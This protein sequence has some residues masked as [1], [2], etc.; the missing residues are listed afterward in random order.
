MKQSFQISEHDAERQ[1]PG[2]LSNSTASEA[3]S[4]IVVALLTGGIDRP[5]TYGLAMELISKGATI[6]VIGSDSLDFPEFHSKPRLNFLNLQG[7]QDPDVSFL[8]KLLRLSSYYA[9][10]I[11]YATTA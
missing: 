10:L 1:A 7:N 2:S 5:Y 9:K 11:R 6:D 8:L 4:A 3:T